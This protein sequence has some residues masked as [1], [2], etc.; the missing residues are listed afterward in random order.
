MQVRDQ[1]AAQKDLVVEAQD[2][3]TMYTVVRGILTVGD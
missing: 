3:I 2:Q 1:E